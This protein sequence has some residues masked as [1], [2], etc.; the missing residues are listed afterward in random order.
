MEEL[1]Q[2][3]FKITKHMHSGG[4]A[5]MKNAARQQPLPLAGAEL[6]FQKYSLAT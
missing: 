6:Y 3:F 2:D 4:L 1:S 5:V